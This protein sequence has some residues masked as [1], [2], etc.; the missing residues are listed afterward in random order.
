L[1][2]KVR[3]RHYQHGVV[4][5]L[6]T[7]RIDMPFDAMSPNLVQHFNCRTVEFT[8]VSSLVVGLQSQQPV[9]A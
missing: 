5:G 2:G 9:F 1:T 7:K 3:A 4:A 8:D 6:P